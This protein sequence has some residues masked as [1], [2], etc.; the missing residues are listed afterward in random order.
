MVFS[1]Y[2][3]ELKP[4]YGWFLDNPQVVHFHWVS[5]K[6]LST[7]YERAGRVEGRRK[8]REGPVWNCAVG[9]HVFF[10]MEI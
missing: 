4:I 5:P 7:I 6:D 9:F 10:L 2:L 3:D 1:W 8:L